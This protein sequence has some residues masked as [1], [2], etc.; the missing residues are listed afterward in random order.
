MLFNVH[1]SVDGT[2]CASCE[3]THFSRIWFSHQPNGSGFRYEVPVSV[4]LILS[5][6]FID[7]GPQVFQI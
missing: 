6:G 4:V 5:L 7:R 3:P 1:V 2:D